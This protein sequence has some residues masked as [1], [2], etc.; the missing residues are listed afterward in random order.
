MLALAEA[1][2]TTLETTCAQP[3]AGTVMA[4]VSLNV[5]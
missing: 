1:P 2:V 3:F 4:F 5:N